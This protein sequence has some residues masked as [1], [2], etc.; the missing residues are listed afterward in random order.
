MSIIKYIYAFS[1][2]KQNHHIIK[3][4]HT[5]VHLLD[6]REIAGIHILSY[7]MW[8]IPNAVSANSVAQ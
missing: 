1:N 2:C 4:D 8:C 6:L 5:V 3:E 7:H